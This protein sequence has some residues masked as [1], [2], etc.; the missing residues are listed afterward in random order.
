MPRGKKY[1]SDTIIEFELHDNQ[2][3]TF[4]FSCYSQWRSVMQKEDQYP[5]CPHI[6]W[7]NCFM[8]HIW[9]L[10]CTN[11]TSFIFI[12]NSVILVIHKYTYLCNTSYTTPNG[13]YSIKI[14]FLTITQRGFY[15]APRMTD[16]R[17]RSRSR[18]RWWGR[19]RW[20]TRPC[21]RT[22]PAPGL[23]SWTAW[24]CLCWTWSWC[25]RT[26]ISSGE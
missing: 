24:S 21:R 13:F 5:Y 20:W 8:N 11:S 3:L 14:F 16:G 19:G 22:F 1:V 15:L 9:I 10:L 17:T 2:C 6:K 7:T 12:R 25:W 18:P 4:V 23:S 26:S